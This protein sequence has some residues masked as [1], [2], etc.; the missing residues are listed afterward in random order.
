MTFAH[1]V[2]APMLILMGEKDYRVPAKQGDEMV[3]ALTK[4][5]ISN[6]EYHV[7]PGEGHGWRKVETILDYVGRMEAF[8]EKWVLER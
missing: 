1:Q 2:K 3:K 6:F 5:G 4:A 7:Y 8:L